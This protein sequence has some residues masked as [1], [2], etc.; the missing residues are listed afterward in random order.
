LQNSPFYLQLDL[1][2]VLA[3]C[4]GPLPGFIRSDVSDQNYLK[5]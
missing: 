1:Q 4:I 2:H 3:K 5:W